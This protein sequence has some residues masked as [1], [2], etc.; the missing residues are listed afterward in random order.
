MKR[1][2]II[3]L[4]V[5]SVFVVSIA[6]FWYNTQPVWIVD[7]KVKKEVLN[8]LPTKNKKTIE[9]IEANGPSLAPSYKV[10]VCTEFVIKVINKA[11]PLTKLEKNDI[12]IITNAAL[13]SLIEAESPIIK[14]VQTAL[15]KS[16]KGTE[17][18]ESTHVLPG[19]FVQFW[20][21]FQG[22]GYGHCGV[23]LDVNPNKTITLYSSHPFTNGY[24]KQEYLW[25]EKIYF[26]RL[27]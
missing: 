13:D 8:N 2:I 23:V 27:K 24:G 20:N 4:I 12:R 15:V 6:I 11:A 9:F 10:A 14:G 26:V 5:I 16:G 17:I 3:C 25:P 7:K 21:V 22:E 18:K 19:D 1:A